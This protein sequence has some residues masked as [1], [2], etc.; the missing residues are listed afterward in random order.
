MHNFFE[1]VHCTLFVKQFIR[2]AYKAQI[3][4]QVIKLGIKLT[5]NYHETYIQKNYR[6]QEK[7]N[8]VKYVVNVSRNGIFMFL[9]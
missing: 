4:I 6:L 7:R 1:S 8:L 9:Q 5:T 2:E 3:N